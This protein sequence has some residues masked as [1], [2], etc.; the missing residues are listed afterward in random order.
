[1]IGFFVN[2]LSRWLN[3][4]TIQTFTQSKSLQADNNCGF[5]GGFCSTIL[6]KDY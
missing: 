3:V 1:M 4:R 6:Y 2:I 5:V